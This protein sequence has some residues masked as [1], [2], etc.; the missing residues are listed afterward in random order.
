MAGAWEVFAGLGCLTRLRA[1]RL[2]DYTE[3]ADLYSGEGAAY[4][5]WS[6][7]SALT[8]L[9]VGHGAVRP[10]VEF[11]DAL[12]ALRALRVLRVW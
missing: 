3:A 4:A 1:L 6:G 10:P 5:A 11:Y 12:P 8:W 2:M 9:E 7:L